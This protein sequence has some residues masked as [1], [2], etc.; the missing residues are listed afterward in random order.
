M[1]K[2]VYNDYGTWVR[3]VLP[4]RVQKISVDAGFTCPN[5]DGRISTGG[6]AFCD[7]RTFNPAYCDPRRSIAGQI[8]A[9]KA[10]FA[11]KYPDMK[12]IAYFQ[13]YSNTY[14]DSVERLRRA[15]EEALAVDGV[16]GLAIATRPDCVTAPVLDYLGRLARQTFLTV[17]YGIESANDLTLRAINRGHD[18]GC[19]R[20]AIEET[21]AR[22]IITCGHVIIGLPGEDAAECLR[23]AP[24][25]SGLKLDILKLH[26]LQVIRGTRLAE[27]YSRKPF[28]TYTAD[29]YMRLVA[30]YLQLLRKDLVIERFVSQSPAGMV[31]A[32]QWGLKNHEFADMLCQYMSQNGIYQGQL[33][34]GG[35]APKPPQ[36]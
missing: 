33:A 9:G 28:P 17:E 10:F 26:Q 24:L 4:G 3:T 1:N 25:V 12:Y 11:R 32:P 35:S 31:I 22:G 36:D 20:R 29:G 7:N 8:E 13:A 23:Q 16:V 21:A 27:E 18:F 34:D 30:A 15:Y 14:A 6:C 2:R 19:S 5:R